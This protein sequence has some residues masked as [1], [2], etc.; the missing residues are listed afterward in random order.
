MK[1]RTNL[2][3]TTAMDTLFIR[4]QENIYKYSTTMLK[5]DIYHTVL[6]KIKLKALI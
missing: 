6:C 1:L 3:Y 2:H 5:N 4:V